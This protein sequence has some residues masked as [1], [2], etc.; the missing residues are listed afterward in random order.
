MIAITG[1]HIVSELPNRIKKSSLMWKHQVLSPSKMAHYIATYSPN[2]PTP[3]LART[4]TKRAS[5][6]LLSEISSESVDR[7]SKRGNAKQN[8]N[9]EFFHGSFFKIV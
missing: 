7:Y 6:F 1:N 5:K 2:P 9:H 4:A 3:M 8:G